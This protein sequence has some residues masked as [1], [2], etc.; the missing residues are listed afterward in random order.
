[1]LLVSVMKPPF[2]IKW[3]A[4]RGGELMKGFWRASRLMNMWRCKEDVIPREG[5]K[6]LHPFATILPVHLFH[7]AVPELYFFEPFWQMINLMR[8]L[9]GTSG[10]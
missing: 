2:K 6:S 10:L 5:I 1:M 3:G 8:V 4:G 9:M 7:L